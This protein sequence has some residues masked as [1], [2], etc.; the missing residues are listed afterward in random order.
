MAPW[1]DVT[2][3][4]CQHSTSGASRVRSHHALV[5]PER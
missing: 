5:H 1:R 2:P 4:H 3:P